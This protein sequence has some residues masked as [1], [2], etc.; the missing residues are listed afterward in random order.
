VNRLLNLF[1]IAC[2]AFIL[3]E[4]VQVF[5]VT[6]FKIPS[7]SM[8]P[9]LLAGD[10]I[11]VDKLAGGARLFDVPAALRKEAVTIHRLS[12]WGRWERNDVLVFNFPYPIGN[13]RDTI[14][15]DVMK[16]FVKRCIALPGDTVEICGGYYRVR[17]YA[18]ALGNQEAQR[19]LSLLPDTT[20]QVVMRS[21]PKYK[22]L[23]WSIKEFGPLP[24]PARGQTV[25]MDSVTYRLYRTL[26][27]WEQ[28]RRVRTDS[29]GQILLGDSVITAYRFRE[30]YY[31]L[32]GDRVENSQDS[33]YW[34]LLPEPFVVGRATRIW[35]S[36]DRETGAVRWS[37]I[38]KKIA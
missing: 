8:E 14:A 20:K 37:R 2:A 15:F 9:A 4:V 1:L 23:G 25:K 36:T 10:N 12:G 24:V 3:L 7:D 21:Y 5:C 26:I 22:P 28:Q 38:F 30:N 35:K 19:R 6:S 29:T 31:F 34:G 16:Y 18:G 11:L 33:R 13:R 27:A 32:A 17:G